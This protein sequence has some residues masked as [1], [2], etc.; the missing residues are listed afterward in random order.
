M[1]QTKKD[2]NKVNVVDTKTGKMIFTKNR[3]NHSVRYPYLSK[4]RLSGKAKEL[5]IVGLKS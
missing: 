5:N 4:G 2:R 3:L 1:S